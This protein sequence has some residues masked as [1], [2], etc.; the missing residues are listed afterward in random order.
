[1]LGVRNHLDAPIISVL[2]GDELIHMPGHAAELPIP[3]AESIAN[4]L[5]DLREELPQRARAKTERDEAARKKS[6][7]TKNKR[8]TGKNASKPV[9]PVATTDAP[10]PASVPTVKLPPVGKAPAAKQV[11]LFN[12]MTGGN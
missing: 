8:A 3:T 2:S 1:M 6:E 5:A 12:F 11:S 4:L 9:R 7:E 10:T